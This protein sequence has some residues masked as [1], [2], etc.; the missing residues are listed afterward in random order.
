MKDIQSMTDQ[1]KAR[2]LN[3]IGV[4][5]MMLE[6]LGKI[7]NSLETEVGDLTKE[8]SERKLLLMKEL[9]SLLK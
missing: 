6:S 9:H 8:F 7:H 5:D 3:K 1:N 4:Y 2:I